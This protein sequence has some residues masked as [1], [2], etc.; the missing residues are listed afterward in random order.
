[1]C[2]CSII[3][4]NLKKKEN[5]G[6]LGASAITLKRWSVKLVTVSSS[7]HPHFC[8][9]ISLWTETLWSQIRTSFK[10]YPALLKFHWSMNHILI[11]KDFLVYTVCFT[12]CESIHIALFYWFY[13]MT[14]HSMR[15]ECWL[16]SKYKNWDCPSKKGKL[17]ALS[18][19]GWHC[20][21]YPFKPRHCW[22]VTWSLLPKIANVN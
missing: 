7:S 16:I 2:S 1:M 22:K 9:R 19:A 13:W 15:G 21:R 11:W 18:E 4:Q 17:T 5:T 20:L 12:F 3:L 6:W 10:P 14:F 8:S